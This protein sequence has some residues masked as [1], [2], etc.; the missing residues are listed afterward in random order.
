MGALL[1]AAVRPHVEPGV[2]APPNLSLAFGETAD[3]R[4]LWPRRAISATK[5]LDEGDARER[6]LRVGLDRASGRV[7]LDRASGD[8]ATAPHGQHE[9]QPDDERGDS[10]QYQ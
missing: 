1:R 7:G 2:D 6:E 5:L 10:D 4:E 8:G 9:D 3:A